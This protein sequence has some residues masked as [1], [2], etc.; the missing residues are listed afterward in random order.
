M[1][2]GMGVASVDE[3]EACAFGG[4]E[5]GEE[6]VVEAGGGAFRA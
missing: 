3:D 2:M 1:A 5:R 4:G 6:A